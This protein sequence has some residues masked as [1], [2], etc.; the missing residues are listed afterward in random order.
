MASRSSTP[1]KAR[2][3]ESLRVSTRCRDAVAWVREVPQERLVGG[4]V[5]VDEVGHGLHRDE[6]HAALHAD[7]G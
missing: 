3:P 5:M 4:L 2:V 6:R 1:A 7:L